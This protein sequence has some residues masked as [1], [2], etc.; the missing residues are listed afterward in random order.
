MRILRIPS[1]PNLSKMHKHPQ[2][3][4]V[5]NEKTNCST[6]P[7]VTTGGDVNAISSSEFVVHD[8]A[9]PFFTNPN[10]VQIHSFENE[11]PLFE[12][13]IVSRTSKVL[14]DELL[15]P[16]LV[17][18]SDIPVYCGIT[19][20]R[21]KDED[22]LN[23]NFEYAYGRRTLSTML[24]AKL[25]T[26]TCDILYINV[27]TVLQKFYKFH[28]GIKGELHG[29]EQDVPPIEFAFSF[30]ES[31][32][33]ATSLLPTGS[34]H[35][36]STIAVAA[37]KER[38]IVTVLAASM[39]NVTMYEQTEDCHAWL[40]PLVTKLSS[41]LGKGFEDVRY[42]VSVPTDSFFVSNLFFVNVVPNA[43]PVDDDE[44]NKRPKS[45]NVVVKKM[46]AETMQEMM[47]AKEQFYN[48]IL[49][50]QKY[51]Q[52]YHRVPRCI[53]ATE[54]PSSDSVI[55]LE[56]VATKRGYSVCKWKYD[57]PLE[58]TLAAFREIARFHAIAYTTKR[59]REKE[60]FDFVDAIE[61][62]RFYPESTLRHMYN[63]TATRSL[64]FLRR[65]G[66][67]RE[68]CDKFEARCANTFDL[69]LKFVEVEEPLAT[70]CHG[71]FTI[72]NMLFKKESDE[73]KVILIDFALIRYGSPILDL[74]TFLCL[75][76]ARDLDK[77][78]LDNVLRAYHDSLIQCLQEND[79]DGEDYSYEALYE[80]YKKKGLFGFFI[81]TFFL[82]IQMGKFDGEMEDFAKM[83][84]TEWAAF[85][86]QIG[87]EEVDEILANMLL[88][89]KEFGCLDYIL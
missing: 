74:S 33:M 6:I 28:F 43:S 5:I 23:L 57:T 64:D 39:G 55:V 20:R 56:N 77:V 22:K 7:D 27:V 29:E 34:V 45:V 2:S 60:F 50:Y 15:L 36:Q 14:L 18:I 78:M 82:A 12:R 73:P 87:G 49:F 59:T 11:L 84:P 32:S 10:N 52:Y 21:K 66:Y 3:D 69:V 79:I 85:S 13:E 38:Q 47:R 30:C 75:H 70:L 53:Y 48:E 35:S 26:I 63:G 83:D 41:I 8:L 19:R 62:A 25:N 46:P 81:A 71:D 76:C 89:L 67:D 42:E 88:K 16:D 54:E 65:Q 1:S 61:E 68:F 58:Y 24:C 44:A 86:R 31:A 72:N 4:L 37:G 51:A 40:G 9:V 80:D 17:Q